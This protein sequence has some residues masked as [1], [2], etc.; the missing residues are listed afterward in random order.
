MSK[1][2]AYS[3]ES[4]KSTESVVDEFKSDDSA[5]D[6]WKDSVE[7]VDCDD[8]GAVEVCVEKSGEESMLWASCSLESD[9]FLKNFSI[10]PAIL[11]MNRNDK[12]TEANTWVC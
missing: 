1:W 8:V 7:L 11:Q 5:R 12:Q 10:V 6:K 9:N 2:D 4:Y 3:C